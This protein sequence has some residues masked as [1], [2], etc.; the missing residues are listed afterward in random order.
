LLEGDRSIKD[1]RFEQLYLEA[2][3]VFDEQQEQKRRSSIALGITAMVLM[4][5]TVTGVVIGLVRWNR[6]SFI[7][8]AFDR[9]D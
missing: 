4:A 6:Q 9:K 3:T 5:F 2:K 8:S 1:E 7:Q